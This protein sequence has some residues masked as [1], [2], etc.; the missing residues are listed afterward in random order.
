[1]VSNYKPMHPKNKGFFWNFIWNMDLW[2]LW[3]M[4]LLLVL[5][6]TVDTVNF[7]LLYKLSTSGILKFNMVPETIIENTG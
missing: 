4:D 7:Y 3:N 5:G 1:M 6:G 2:F